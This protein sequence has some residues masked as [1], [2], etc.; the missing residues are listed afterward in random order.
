MHINGGEAVG[1]KGG[2][3][4]SFTG[5]TEEMEDLVCHRNH[6]N[7]RFLV[8]FSSCYPEINKISVYL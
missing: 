4:H 2:V 1:G 6:R 8:R 5:S 3:A 7:L